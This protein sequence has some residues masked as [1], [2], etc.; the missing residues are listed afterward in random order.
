MNIF[1][2]KVAL[3]TGGGTGIGRATALDFAAKGASI[4]VADLNAEEGKKTVEVA[5]KRAITI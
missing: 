5:K 2:G 3:V 4:V 1:E